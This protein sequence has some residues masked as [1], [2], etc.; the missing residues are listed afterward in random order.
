MEKG[1][2]NKYF[3]GVCLYSNLTVSATWQSEAGCAGMR[4][5]FF[6][7]MATWC[8]HRK[9]EVRHRSPLPSHRLNSSRPLKQGQEVVKM[10]NL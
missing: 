5:Q 10:L 1:K 8:D 2:T 9:G 4:G 7:Q 3:V 6:P